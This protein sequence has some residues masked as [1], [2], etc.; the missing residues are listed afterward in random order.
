MSKKEVFYKKCLQEAKK[1]YNNIVSTIYKYMEYFEQIEKYDN[2]EYDC[3]LSDKE[4]AEID[5][6][7]I[8]KFSNK[9]WEQFD[10]VE[11]NYNIVSFYLLNDL[12]IDINKNG[13]FKLI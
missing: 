13:A 6:I 8:E 5:K 3:K 1:D 4:K 2:G 12:K 10:R 11:M 9:V 7:G